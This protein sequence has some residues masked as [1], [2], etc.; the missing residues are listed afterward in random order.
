MNSWEP[1]SFRA[2]R[3]QV[4]YKLINIVIFFKSKKKQLI[5]ISYPN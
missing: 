5:K 3:L 2:G 4:D 1:P